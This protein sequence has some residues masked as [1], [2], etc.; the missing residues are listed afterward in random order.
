M[1]KQDFKHFKKSFKEDWFGWLLQFLMVIMFF[2]LFGYM[3]YSVFTDPKP[4]HM[5]DEEVELIMSNTVF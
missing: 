5:N 1:D 3:V 2:G 4:I